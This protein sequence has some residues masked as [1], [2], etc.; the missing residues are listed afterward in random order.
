MQSNTTSMLRPGSVSV[1]ES[2]LISKKTGSESSVSR[3]G[4]VLAW[5][6]EW[7]WWVWGNSSETALRRD[8]NPRDGIIIRTS[9]HYTVGRHE[10]RNAPLTVTAGVFILG[11]EEQLITGDV[12]SVLMGKYENCFQK[13]SA[14]SHGVTSHLIWICMNVKKDHIISILSYLFFL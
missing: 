13:R 10:W 2:S 14:D 9:A 11:R 7:K 5:D 6:G 1:A 4:F 8:T 3:W 12:F